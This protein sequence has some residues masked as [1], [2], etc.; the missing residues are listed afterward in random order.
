MPSL[1]QRERSGQPPNPQPP[2]CPACGSKM[3]LVM[4]NPARS[5]YANLDLWTYACDPC[6]ETVDNY[7]ARTNDR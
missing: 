6:G 7:V 3:K 5:S 4:V 2:A 1:G